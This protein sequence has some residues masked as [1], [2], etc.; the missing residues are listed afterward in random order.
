MVRTQDPVL[1]AVLCKLHGAI[2]EFH[3]TSG[4]GA[5]VA[6][7]AQGHLV[8]DTSDFRDCR[9][10]WSSP[11]ATSFISSSLFEGQVEAMARSQ[12]T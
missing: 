10:L 6:I 3:Q 12:S 11:L 9:D 8:V 7:V 2:R 4:H 5:S 1:E